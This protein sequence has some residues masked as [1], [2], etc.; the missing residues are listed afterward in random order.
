VVAGERR[1][2]M[3]R[4]RRPRGG[5]RR[6]DRPGAHPRLLVVEDDPAIRR[7]LTRYLRARHFHVDAASDGEAA[8]ACV[9]AV[10]PHLIV[11][12]VQLPRLDG[13]GL[14]A[15]LAA[16][17]DTRDIPVIIFSAEADA[18]EK[19]TELGCAAVLMKPASPRTLLEKIRDT[20]RSRPDI[21]G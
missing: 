6:T 13:Y 1:N 11:T 8:L 5:R 19:A 10:R 7:L 15:R 21:L 18:P 9:A 14:L 16:Q 20:L 12:D 3:D 4:R 2:P 17:P